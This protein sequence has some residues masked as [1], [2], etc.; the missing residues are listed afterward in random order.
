MFDSRFTVNTVWPI[1]VPEFMSESI[2]L[3]STCTMSS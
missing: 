2:V 3:C 1:S